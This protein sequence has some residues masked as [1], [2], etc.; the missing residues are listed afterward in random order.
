[1]FYPQFYTT[2][3]STSKL[4]TCELYVGHLVLR[5]KF[6]IFP[7][8]CLQGKLPEMAAVLLREIVL[9][10][11]LRHLQELGKLLEL[12]DSEMRHLSQRQHMGL[13]EKVTLLQRKAR[14]LFLWGPLSLSK[15]WEVCALWYRE[16][17]ELNEVSNQI[18][19]L[20]SE[21]LDGGLVVELKQS[22]L[23]FTQLRPLIEEMEHEIGMSLIFTWKRGTKD[24]HICLLNI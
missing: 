18:E 3:R 24:N 12:L 13:G 7:F 15:Y 8:R 16:E 4:I 19:Q 23:G 11:M 21:L 10:G 14:E 9:E 1:M 2:S 20:E 6:N 5:R 17:S 22:G